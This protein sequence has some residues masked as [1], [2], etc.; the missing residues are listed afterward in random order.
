MKRWALPVI[1]GVM[2]FGF[3]GDMWG[4]SETSRFLVPLLQLM[5]PW[6]SPET[7]FLLHALVRKLAHVVEY[8]ILAVLWFRAFDTD[9]SGRGARRAVMRSLLVVIPW[10][11]ADEYRQTWT[12]TR[13][14]TLGDVLLDGAGAGAALCLWAMVGRRLTLR[15]GRRSRSESPSPL[16]GDAR[17]DR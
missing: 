5:F 7:I 2:I 11:M 3:S 10:A 12:A 1:W 13:S 9:S 6:A 15:R 8:G 14:G 4:A 16:P 17:R